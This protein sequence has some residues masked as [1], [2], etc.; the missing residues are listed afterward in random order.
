MIIQG[1]NLIIRAGGV[2]IAAARSCSVS[3]QAEQI[4]ISSPMSG[5][6]AAYLNGM[7]SWS[8]ST[9]HLVKTL[10]NALMVGTQ[11]SLEF[12]VEGDGLPFGGF[13]DN[14]TLQSGACPTTP[15]AVVWDKTR[16]K[17]LAFLYSSDFLFYQTWEGN[18]PYVGMQDYQTFRNT[19]QND[20][21]YT[22]VDGDLYAEKLSGTANVQAYEAVGTVGNL[23]QGSF[24]FIGSGALDAAEL[25]NT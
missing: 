8:V 15:T 23:A 22:W 24:K 14:P 21:T 20:E 6:W 17:F 4:P 7:K 5:A 3:I 9:N 16:K 11:V 12:G 19:E 2:A 18:Q 1:R 10:R 25:P 13:V